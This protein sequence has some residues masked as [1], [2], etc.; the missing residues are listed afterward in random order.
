MIR[1]EQ[2]TKYYGD[3]PAVSDV[4]FSIADGEV[5]GLLG[6]NGAGK[7]TIL[8]MLSGLLLPTSGSVVIDNLDLVQE[9]EKARARIGFLPEQPPVY[10]EM[11][12]ES[13][14]TFVAN[15]KG[16]RSNVSHALEK[17]MEATD[18]RGVRNKPIAT[19]SHGFTRRVGIA[20]AIVHQPALILLDEPTSGL[21]PV[22]I[23]NMR[24]LVRGLSGGNTILISSHNL[25]EIHEVC[26]RILVLERGRIIGEGSEA[27]LAHRLTVTTTIE[28]EVRGSADQLK[29]ALQTVEGVHHIRIENETQDVTCAA[30]E[31]TSDARED[32]SKAIVQAGLGLRSLQRR[33]AELENIFLQL[34]K[35]KD[36]QEGKQGE[37]A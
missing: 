4:S 15:I 8:K 9:P 37:H 3:H 22:Q 20:Q 19:L 36:V 14:L 6:L 24:G 21:D 23:V 31:L 25:N 28:L 26:D 27:D 34:T 11:T 33:Q 18:L 7:T 10:A 29:N 12:V 32:L 13:Y 30:I 1:A 35:T 17:A 5:V 2:L 16:F